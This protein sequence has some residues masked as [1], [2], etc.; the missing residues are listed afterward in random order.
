MLDKGAGRHATDFWST[1]SSSK[2]HC[3]H[4]DR[5][6]H[7]QYLGDIIVRELLVL[8]LVLA[9][10]GRKSPPLPSVSTLGQ[11]QQILSASNTCGRERNGV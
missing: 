8:V 2:I 5:T 6:H 7:N 11:V 3:V 10:R 1:L 9:E 4:C